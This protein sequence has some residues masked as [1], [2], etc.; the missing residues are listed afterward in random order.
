MSYKQLSLD[1]FSKSNSSSSAENG[2]EGVRKIQI[3]LE[4]SKITKAVRVRIKV[5]WVLLKSSLL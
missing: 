5:L 1:I 3:I 4:T 2:V